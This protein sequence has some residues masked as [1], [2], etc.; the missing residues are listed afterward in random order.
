MSTMMELVSEYIAVKKQRMDL[1][2]K[3]T[4]LKTG[5]EEE[6][7]RL[8]LLE[9]SAQNL[10]SA[11]IDGVG[12]IT[13]KNTYRYEIKN[14]ELLAYRMFENMVKCLQ[15]KR[16]LT[17][18]LLFQQRLSKTNVE[19]YLSILSPSGETPELLASFGLSKIEEPNL[20]VTKS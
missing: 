19:D 14:V 5:R 3:A 16:P 20:S 9:M 18:A 11:H 7:K 2:K 10:K 8:I 15:E 12:R 4:E 6:L 13:Q 17:D 1:E